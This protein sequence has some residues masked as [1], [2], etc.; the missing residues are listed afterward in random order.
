MIE[1][2][3][4]VACSARERLRRRQGRRDAAGPGEG[5]GQALQGGAGG[6][7][8]RPERPHRRRVRVP[9]TE[10]RRQ[11]D[12]AAHGARPDHA[13][14]GHGRAVRARSDTRGRA[15]AGGRR[16]VRGGAALLPVPDR[17]QEPG[18]A[19]RAGRRRREGAYRRGAADRRAGPARGPP[20][21]RLLA[22]D[23][24]AARDRRGTA[25]PP[26]PADPRRARHRP[27]PG[28]DARHAS[29]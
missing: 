10:R 5:T 14:R 3:P 17:A 13:H 22:R 26:A 1:D 16:R 23:A 8:H 9:G 2:T 12:D 28:G 11:D 6:R 25:A 24:P 7:S 21:R 20:R 19:R 4:P 27:R 15:R 18:A 29:C